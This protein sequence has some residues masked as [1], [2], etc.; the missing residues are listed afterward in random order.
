MTKVEALL[1]LMKDNGGLASW[2]FI[3]NNLEKYYPK[4]KESEEWQAGV[5]GTLYRE[6][7]SGTNFKKVGIGV[8]GLIDYDSKV[9][10]EEIKSDT[11]RMH[12]YIQGVMIELGNYEKYDTYSPDASAIFQQNIKVGEISSMKDVP[13]FSYQ[14]IVDIAKRIDV[15]YFN[16]TGYQFP[17]R[18]IEIVDSIGTLESSLSRVYQLKGFQADFVILTPERYVEKVQRTLNKE[19][20]S[21]ERERFIVR[22]YDE[23]LKFYKAKVEAEN[24]KF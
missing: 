21:I 24:L 12:S 2:Q 3:Y 5:R 18:A 9:I 10:E 4:I 11:V 1:Q 22:N 7:R 13:Q 6:I 20:Y 15:L 14:A 19:P 16:T 17:R 23:V 8:F